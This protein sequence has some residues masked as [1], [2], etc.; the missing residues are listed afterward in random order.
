MSETLG[1]VISKMYSNLIDPHTPSVL[2]VR[3]AWST[4]MEEELDGYTWEGALDHVFSSSSNARPILIQ[5]KILIGPGQ[6]LV[7]LHLILTP[8][9]LDA[10]LN[11][12]PY[13]ISCGPALQWLNYETRYL[14]VSLISNKQ[15]SNLLHVSLC[16][17]FYW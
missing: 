5:C 2:G 8:P 11:L 17:E 16:L 6:R 10:R 4:D 7:R 1:G 9:L 13:T 15:L 12:P 14:N 3:G